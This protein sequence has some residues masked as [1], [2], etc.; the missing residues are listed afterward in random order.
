MSNCDSYF[1]GNIKTNRSKK[2]KG[3]F[4]PGPA[5]NNSIKVPDHSP[6]LRLSPEQQLTR[7]KIRMKRMAFIMLFP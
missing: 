7:M 3:K 6:P 1:Q 4:C 2:I 5:G